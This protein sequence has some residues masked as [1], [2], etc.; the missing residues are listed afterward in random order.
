MTSWQTHKRYKPQTYVDSGGQNCDNESIQIDSC[1][2]HLWK[3]C[4]NTEILY[5][6]QRKTQ[7]LFKMLLTF[8]LSSQCP[9][10]Y[11]YSDNIQTQKFTMCYHDYEIVAIHHTSQMFHGSGHTHNSTIQMYDTRNKIIQELKQ[12]NHLPKCT[13]SKLQNSKDLDMDDSDEETITDTEDNNM[14]N[15]CT[16]VLPN[17]NNDIKQNNS[18]DIG[19]DVEYSI[20]E[21]QF[22]EID[23]VQ[24]NHIIKNENKD[25][26]T[27]DNSINT[28][29]DN[30]TDDNYSELNV[31]IPVLG[32]GY[33]SNINHDFPLNVLVSE[34]VFISGHMNAIPT[35][36]ACHNSDN[37]Q[38][39]CIA[40]K[41]VKLQV[42]FTTDWFDPFK[43]SWLCCVSLTSVDD[44]YLCCVL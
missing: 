26:N 14:N 43:L 40:F 41:N 37:T 4:Q 18:N 31:N 32:Q 12:I 8:D 19:M 36:Q 30:N 11:H 24:Y 23:D 7:H 9:V 25:N 2:I 3:H 6:R 10:L 27:N 38:G 42:N 5:I 17:A 20:K 15:N 1:M 28:S 21:E 34:P 13:V 22:N 39:E 35:L 29:N 33:S 44:I 16:S